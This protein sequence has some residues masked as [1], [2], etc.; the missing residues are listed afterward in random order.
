MFS[1]REVRPAPMP[2]GCLSEMSQAILEIAGEEVARRFIHPASFMHYQIV[3]FDKV[4]TALTYFPGKPAIQVGDI[5]E[6]LAHDDLLVGLSPC[7]MGDQ[8]DLTSV[9]AWTSYPIKIAIY[10]GEDGPLET[11]PD[12]QRKSM[13]AVDFN[14]AGRPGLV[15]GKVGTKE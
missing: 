10:E 13:N 7:P 11:A 9:E 8:T 3:A 15:T 6:L 12:P 2:D 1:R 4:P 5:V 14:L